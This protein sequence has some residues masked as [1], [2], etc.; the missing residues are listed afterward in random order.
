[1]T[2]ADVRNM[3]ELQDCRERLLR[4]AID[5]LRDATYGHQHFD[6][7]GRS[8]LGCEVCRRHEAA[9]QEARALLAQLD[10]VADP[11]EVKP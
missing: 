4:A 2:E 3:M 7:T 8:G 10:L 6:P 1:M 9:R 5:I 11:S